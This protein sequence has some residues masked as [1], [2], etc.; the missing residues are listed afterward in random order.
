MKSLFHP[1]ALTSGLLNAEKRVFFEAGFEFLNNIF[2]GFEI[3]F[4]RRGMGK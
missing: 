3:K 4:L 2:N 1:T